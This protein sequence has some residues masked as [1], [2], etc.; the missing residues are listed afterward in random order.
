M[1][2]RNT[3]ILSVTIAAGFSLGTALHPFS[4]RADA[5]SA[6]PNATVFI[7]SFSAQELTSHVISSQ[8]EGRQVVGFSC[9][10]SGAKAGNCYV[11]SVK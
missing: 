1:K 8:V 11:A 9:I 5:H 10:T 4:A 7:T 6:D 2:T 3:L